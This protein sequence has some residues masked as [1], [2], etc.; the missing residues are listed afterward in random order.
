[1]KFYKYYIK[2]T[3][4]VYTRKQ[5]AAKQNK[6]LHGNKGLLNKTKTHTGTRGC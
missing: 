3:Y 2:N 6:N 1:M 5:G 4:T